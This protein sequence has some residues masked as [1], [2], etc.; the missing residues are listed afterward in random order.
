MMIDL[1]KNIAG[2]EWDQP[3][4]T[5]LY[6]WK[7]SPDF[8]KSKHTKKFSKWVDSLVD[9]DGMIDTFRASFPN[10][11][12]RFTCFNQYTNRRYEN[13]G[14]RIDYILIDGSLSNNLREREGNEGLSCGNE[15]VRNCEERSDELGMRYSA[16]F[17]FTLVAL[18]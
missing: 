8:F 16:R 7:R 14:A 17:S 10:A 12:G 6:D 3:T 11:E 4:L 13:E 15:K 2:V 1:L 18:V 9:E 5:E